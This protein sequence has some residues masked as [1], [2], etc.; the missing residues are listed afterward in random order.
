[1]KGTFE[2]KFFTVRIREDNIVHLVRTAEPYP[3]LGA[4]RAAYEDF[5]GVVDEWL[6]DRR[7]KGMLIGTQR[8]IPFGWLYDVRG[9]P[10]ARN[11]PEFEQTHHRLRHMMVDRSPALAAVVRS[12]AGSM[13]LKRMARDDNDAY[14]TTNDEQEAI[15]FLLKR[16]DE[17]DVERRQAES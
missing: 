16:M 4:V 1:V 8:W 10:A 9:A 3:V 11:D 5:C 12:V 14:F 2:Q 13:Q 17:L 15:D 6:F 7:M